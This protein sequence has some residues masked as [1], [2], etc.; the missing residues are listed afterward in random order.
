M[1]NIL[2]VGDFM[3]SKKICSILCSGLLT[4]SII[5]MPSQKVL[6]ATIN[7]P[8]EVVVSE[9]FAKSDQIN[10]RYGETE[11]ITVVGTEYRTVTV[12]PSGQPPQ[13]NN[14]PNGGGLYVNTS[15]GP[16]VSFSFGL[17]WGHASIG[18]SIGTA[19]PNYA[20]GGKYISFPADK[21]YYLAKIDKRIKFERHKV[22]VYQYNE[23]KYTYYTTVNSVISESNYLVRVYGYQ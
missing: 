8:N 16:N 20:V 14:F 19:S 12:T 15:S 1:E 10:P 22:D 9:E 6:A 21:Y 4:F 23:Y 5:T 11:Q 18:L 7:N 13:G 2:K 3:F 17:S